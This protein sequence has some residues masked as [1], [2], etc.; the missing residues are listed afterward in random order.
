MEERPSDGHMVKKFTTFYGTPKLI[1]VF[2]GAHHPSLT[3]PQL[4]AYILL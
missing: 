4:T 3:T 1:A 2:T